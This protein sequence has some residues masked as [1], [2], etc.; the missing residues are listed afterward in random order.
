MILYMVE[1]LLPIIDNIITSGPSFCVDVYMGR[2]GAY[3]VALFTRA[4][5]RIMSNNDTLVQG[6]WGHCFSS[7]AKTAF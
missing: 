1:A 4:R 7:I 5:V 3:V 6:S 2:H